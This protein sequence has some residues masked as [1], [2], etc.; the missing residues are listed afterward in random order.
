MEGGAGGGHGAL[1][2]GRWA[3]G[4]HGCPPQ[5]PADDCYRNMHAAFYRDVGAYRAL[6]ETPGCLRW[7]TAFHVFGGPGDTG[8]IEGRVGGQGHRAA[9]R[10]GSGHAV[11]GNWGVLGGTGR[12]GHCGEPL[13][14]QGVRNWRHWE[15]LVEE[16]GV[17]GDT[18]EHWGHDLGHWVVGA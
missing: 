7:N 6:L 2:R 5:I 13:G 11:G 3:Q 18:G 16:F 17:L 1:A 4:T 12:V 10:A 14:R 8:D 15:V 9:L